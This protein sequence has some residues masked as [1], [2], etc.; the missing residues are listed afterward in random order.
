MAD[1]TLPCR[2]LVAAEIMHFRQV[3]EH[4]TGFQRVESDEPSARECIFPTQK[5]QFALTA[6]FIKPTQVIE[7]QKI[8]DEPI[9]HY[10]RHEIRAHRR[11]SRRHESSTF[12]IQARAKQA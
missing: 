8:L 2:E 3:S 7:P 10:K 9:R 5:R 11:R 12:G 1:R 4:S 6:H